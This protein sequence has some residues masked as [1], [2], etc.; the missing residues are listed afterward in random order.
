MS[1][2]IPVDD[3]VTQEVPLQP[4]NRQAEEAVL[5]SILINPE[6]YFDLAQ[7]IRSDDFYIIRNQW[8]WDVFVQL[9]ERRQPIDY[10]TVCD[11]LEQRNQLTEIGGPA[12]VM[13]LI[14]QTPS[15][16]HAVAYAQIV[17]DTSVRR[18]MLSAA[19]NL[20]KLAFD[21]QKNIDDILND[22][23]KSIFGISERRTR[24]DLEP[25]NHVLSEV[26]DRVDQLYQRSEEIFGVP[27]GLVD[28]DRWLG[29]LQRSD[30]LI[31]A[32]RPGIGKT[33]FLLSAA[34]NAAQK[35]KKNVAMFSLEMSNEQ[36]VQ[37]LL[38]QETGN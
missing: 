3:V 17:A 1:D 13:A 30:L 31:V 11:E 20:A 16:L 29:G 4:H 6:S 37:R 27:T 38:A 14:N 2:Q 19:N 18:R 5:G 32:G 23:E 33:G 7:V 35:Y 15:S 10:V 28:L 8:I 26:L 12:Y 25:I 22:A 24:G 36:L 21:Q 34:K 9:Q